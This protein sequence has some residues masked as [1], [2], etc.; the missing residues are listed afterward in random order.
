MLDAWFNTINGKK[1]KESFIKN[2]QYNSFYRIDLHFV[3]R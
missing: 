3:S 1:G 2:N